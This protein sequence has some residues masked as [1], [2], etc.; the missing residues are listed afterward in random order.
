MGGGGIYYSQEERQRLRR[1]YRRAELLKQQV[2]DK[3][4][5][6]LAMD[7]VDKTVAKITN[8]VI[9]PG[10]KSE[11]R[12][13]TVMAGE[14]MDLKQSLTDMVFIHLKRHRKVKA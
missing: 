4:T 5:L 13:C 10:P 12:E 2:A 3:K 9:R 8:D 1:E 6:K 7:I 11:E 14:L